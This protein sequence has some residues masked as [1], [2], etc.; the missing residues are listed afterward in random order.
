LKTSGFQKEICWNSY[1]ELDESKRHSRWNWKK[2]A[3]DMFKLA[4]N[5]DRPD[6]KSGVKT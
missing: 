3:Q 2:A 4:E 1:L 5:G 6:K